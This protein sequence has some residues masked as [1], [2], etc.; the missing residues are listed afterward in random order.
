A[1]K[2]WVCRLFVK[3]EAF[4]GDT[5]LSRVVH[6]PPYPPLDGR[7]HVR[8]VQHDKGIAAAQLHRALLES[9]ARFGCNCRTG[10]LAARQR[11]SLDP[12]VCDR[13]GRLLI[14]E[15][16][17]AVGTHWSASIQEQL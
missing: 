5:T 9:L 12:R 10:P 2:E 13:S 11:H 17:V 14:R 8:I 6:A 7:V 16:H 1:V 4:R 15:K 3:D